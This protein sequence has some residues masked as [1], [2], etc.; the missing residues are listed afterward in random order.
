MTLSKQIV[1]LAISALAASILLALAACQS[2]GPIGSAV[3]ASSAGAPYL[4]DIRSDNGLGP[5]TPDARLEQ[6]AKQ[7]AAYMA[8]SGKM[9]HNT[10]WGRGFAS[11]MD[12]NG[13]DGAAAENVAPG[14]MEPEKLFSMWMNSAGHRRNMLDPRFTRFGLA[15]AAAGGSGERYWAL[16]LGR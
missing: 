5:L 10:G 6:A 14:R 2:T 8:R 15:S 7:Q 12:K 13:V 3:G 1:R 9:A 16:V 11:R 4:A